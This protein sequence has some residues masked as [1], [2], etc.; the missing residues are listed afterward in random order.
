MNWPVHGSR[1]PLA[2]NGRRRRRSPMTRVVLVTRSVVLALSRLRRCSQKFEQKAATT[3]DT[4][5]TEGMEREGAD[6]EGQSAVLSR[7]I[8]HWGLVCWN[9]L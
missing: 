9:Q 5:G 3:E 1:D 6:G 4:E 2:W 8:G 7:S